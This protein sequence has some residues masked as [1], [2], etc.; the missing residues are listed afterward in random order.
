MFVCLC[1]CDCLI[2]ILF[3]KV[4]DAKSKQFNERSDTYSYGIVTWECMTRQYP[5]SEFKEYINSFT[6]K[7]NKK[8]DLKFVFC[9]IFFF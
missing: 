4:I 8:K 9:N 3:L 5:F 2:F 7:H 6:G 1:V